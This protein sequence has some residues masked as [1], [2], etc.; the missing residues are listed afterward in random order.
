MMTPAAKEFL[1]R[2]R[3]GTYTFDADTR[4]GWLRLRADLERVHA[5]VDWPE[6]TRNHVWNEAVDDALEISPEETSVLHAALLYGRLVGF[7]RALVDRTPKGS[8]P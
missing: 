1:A 2:V 3:S 8:L 7:T 5:T 6:W 4:E